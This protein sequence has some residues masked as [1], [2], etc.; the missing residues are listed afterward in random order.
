MAHSCELICHCANSV[1]ANGPRHQ[2]CEQGRARGSRVIL[3][4]LVGKE[5][6]LG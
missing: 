4:K 3:Y 6:G 2:F 5:V 1:E